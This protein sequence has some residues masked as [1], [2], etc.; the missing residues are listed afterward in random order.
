MAIAYENSTSHTADWSSTLTKSLDAGTNDD[1]CVLVFVITDRGGA[2]T[3]NS[4]TYG[5]VSMTAHTAFTSTASGYDGRLFYLGGAA[6]GAND[7]VV[8]LSDG[9]TKPKLCAVAYSGVDGTTPVDQLTNY[10]PGSFTSTPS[11][12]ISSAS[13]DLVV[14][15]LANDQSRTGTPGSPANE[16]FD[17]LLGTGTFYAQI[18]DEAGAASV[19]IDETLSG[20]SE[21]WGVA[22]NLNAASAGATGV[23]ATNRFL[24][25]VG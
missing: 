22:L 18:L 1:R 12:T 13:G 15:M 4:A 21:V 11:Q 14:L 8:T 10:A 19:T 17:G 24:M 5:G 3:I 20:S 25:G 9:N 6:S 2:T 7:I 23:P 16:R